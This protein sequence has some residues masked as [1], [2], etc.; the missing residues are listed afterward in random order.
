MLIDVHCHVY[1]GDIEEIAERARQNGVGIIV[2]SGADV[3]SNRKTLKLSD[4]FAEFKATMGLYPMD[5]LRMSDKK[6]DNEIE[7]IRENKDSIV[8]ISEVGMDFSEEE[9][10]EDVQRKNFKKFVELAKELNKPLIV[11]SRKAEKECIELL[12]KLGAEKVVMHCF[13]GNFKLIHRI[14]DNGWFLSIPA[15]VKSSQHFQKV[16]SEVPISNLLCETD[17]PYLHPDKEFPNEPAN[18]LVSYEFIAKIKGISLKETEKKIE[19][20]YKKLFY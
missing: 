12:E 16:I 6:I 20:N 11:H 1:E 17:S 18:V 4:E 19:S 5:A 3:S 14:V 9:R 10:N 2:N 13:S 15:S 7:F 8:A